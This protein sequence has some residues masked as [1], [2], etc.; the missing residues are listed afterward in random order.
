M[1]EVILGSG[2]QP[3]PSL[4]DKTVGAGWFPEPNITS[5]IQV[6]LF[7]IRKSMRRIEHPRIT[8]LRRMGPNCLDPSVR[9]KL[10][11]REIKRQLQ[12]QKL[13]T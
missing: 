8:T 3:A 4:L 10:Q 13:R 6:P 11:P 1:A 9:E 5:A 2:N 7:S 12:H